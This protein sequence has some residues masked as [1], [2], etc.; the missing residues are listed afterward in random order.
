[1]NTLRQQNTDL[2]ST[3]QRLNQENQKITLSLNEATERQH[4]LEQ[5]V[6]VCEEGG[7]GGMRIQGA[8]A[9]SWAQPAA[10][11]LPQV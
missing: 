6:R 3:V 10:N 11:A 7:G 5:R 4:S 8:P 9:Q 1:M 2:Q